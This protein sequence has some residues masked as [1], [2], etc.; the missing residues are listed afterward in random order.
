VGYNIWH[1]LGDGDKLALV[2]IYKEYYDELFNYGFRICI[3]EDL[4]RDCIQELFIKI[5]MDRSKYSKIKNPKPYIFRVLRNTI[6]DHLKRKEDC[7]DLDDIEFIDPFLSEQDFAINIETS[8]DIKKKL[9]KA[10]DKL[11]KR[12]KEIIFLKFYSGLNYKEISQITSIQQ[13]SIRNIMTKALKKLR[14]VIP[15]KI[16]EI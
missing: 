10:I 11:T 4:T 8:S 14:L 15:K 7:A 16:L 9:S 3:S 2:K 1:N 6:V 12:Q 13:Q 5:W